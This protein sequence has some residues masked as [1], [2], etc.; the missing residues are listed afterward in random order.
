MFETANLLLNP[1]THS[2]LIKYNRADGSL[3][4]E[5]GLNGSSHPIP[6]ELKEVPGVR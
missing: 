4:A 5:L 1:L 6:P 3:E 2:K